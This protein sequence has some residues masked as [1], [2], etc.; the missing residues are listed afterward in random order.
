MAT[1]STIATFEP[2][3]LI[4]LLANHAETLRSVHAAG[5][6][7]PVVCLEDCDPRRWVPWGPREVCTNCGTPPLAANTWHKI[8]TET[9]RTRRAELG[10]VA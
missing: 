2:Y 3:E 4:I 6:A 5:A 1:L 7:M 9:L 10:A 8:L